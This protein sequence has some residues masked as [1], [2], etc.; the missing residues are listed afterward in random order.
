MD[1]DNDLSVT[2]NEYESFNNKMLNENKSY[3]K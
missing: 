1:E 2:K 3:V